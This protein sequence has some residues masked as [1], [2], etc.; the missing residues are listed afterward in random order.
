MPKGNFRINEYYNL[1]NKAQQEILRLEYQ[2]RTGNK[3]AQF[4][5][6]LKKESLSA[7][8]VLFFARIF[9]VSMENLFNDPIPGPR[10]VANLTIIAE[11]RDMT[12]D[13]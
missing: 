3:L 12:I 1:L 9:G 13:G 2:K 8:K 10:P 5:F 6:D 7:G 11:Q 4:Y